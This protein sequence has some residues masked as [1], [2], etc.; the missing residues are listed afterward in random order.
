M[1]ILNTLGEDLYIR[2]L[3]PGKDVLAAAKYPASGSFID[4]ADFERFGFYAALD[5][6]ADA[7][8][9]KVQ[10]ATAVDGTPKDITSAAKTDIADTDDGTE[11][12]I[13]VQTDHLDI[14]NDYRYVTLD[15]S[16]I[17]GNNYA[18][19]I[20]FGV[21]KSKPVTQPTTLTHV[22]VAG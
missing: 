21:P 10:Q 1:S 17:S 12:L 3:E 15:V 19:L 9:L 4:V 16:G 20:F 8:D 6:L 18:A 13:E 22:L 2:V 7:V 5:T 11:V 14:N